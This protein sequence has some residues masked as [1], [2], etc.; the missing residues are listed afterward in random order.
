MKIAICADSH[1]RRDHAKWA[2]EAIKERSIDTAL[3]LG[4]FCAPPIML[5][6]AESG[7]QWYGVWGN[8]D[9]DRLS[10]YVRT[11]SFANFD[12][13]TSDFRELE[14]GGKKLFLTH[15]PEIARIAALSGLYDAVFYGHDHT[16]HQEMVGKTLLANPGELAGSRSGIVSF[17]IY[18][19]DTNSFDFVKKP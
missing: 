11:E 15:Y 13:G 6:L 18:D 16:M 14:L 2:V 10:G 9:G 17:A 12:I 5:D 7:L 8:V 1:D 4:D 19:T 3:H